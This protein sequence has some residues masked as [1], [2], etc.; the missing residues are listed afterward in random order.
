MTVRRLRADEVALVKTLRL[1]ALAGAPDAFAHTHA[2]IRAKP[3]SYWLE[4]IRS[5]TEPG[6][7]AMFVAQ[8][9]DTP[10]GM[11]FGLIDVEHPARAHLGGMWVDPAARGRGVGRALCDAVIAWARERGLVDIVLSVT[12]G[13]TTAQALYERQGFALTGRRGAHPHNPS[14][15]I[16]YM[17]RSL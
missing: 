4:L 15:A 11:A 6:R 12:E 8:L 14:L 9:A 16:L 1:R 10:V 3:D 2:E 7:H 13:N 5:V 17:E